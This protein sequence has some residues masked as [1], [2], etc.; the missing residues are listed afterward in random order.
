M[1]KHEEQKNYLIE[2]LNK[3][4]NEIEN[5]ELLKDDYRNFSTNETCDS[6]LKEDIIK[7]Y[8]NLNDSTSN[9]MKN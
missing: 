3:V 8:N 9:F 4:F 1:I 7:A 2:K 6:K 5:S